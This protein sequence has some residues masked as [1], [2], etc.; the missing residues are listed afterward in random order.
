MYSALAIFKSAKLELFSNGSPLS[1]AFKKLKKSCLFS[2]DLILNG[3]KDC[4]NK[5]CSGQV[6]LATDLYS[7]Q[8]LCSDS[9]G[10][11]PPL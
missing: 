5:N 2:L 3:S 7:S 10:V 11:N 8:Y 6:K 4:L 1:T 9:F